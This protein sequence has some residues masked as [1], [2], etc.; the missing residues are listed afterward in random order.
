[1]FVLYN[2]GY[3]IGWRVGVRVIKYGMRGVIGIG[4]RG[5]VRDNL[6]WLHP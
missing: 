1:M 5:Y 3:L 2:V 6:P 4:E